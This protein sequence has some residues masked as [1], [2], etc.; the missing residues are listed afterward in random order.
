VVL[1]DPGTVMR[2]D[3]KPVMASPGPSVSLKRCFVR[4]SGDL[5]NCRASRPFRLEA[6]QTLVALS[7]SVLI[8]DAGKYDDSSDAS[9][10][11]E[12]D[13]RNVT[14]V[15]GGNLLLLR[16]ATPRDQPSEDL[17]GIVP[18]S[19]TPDGCL[20]ASLGGASS[21]RALVSI[22]RG[23]A[24]DATLLQ[25]IPWKAGKNAYSFPEFIDQPLSPDDLKSMKST[26]YNR[27][28]WKTFTSETDARFLDMVKLSDI[29]EN[30]AR[31][32]PS[33][34]VLP[35]LKDYGP[36]MEKLPTPGK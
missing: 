3:P 27:E 4:G 5:V 7:G 17:K 11:S 30:L 2:K 35:E 18:V 25:K 6:Q 19:W 1:A 32:R 29:P 33:Q 12:V 26:P 9:P 34:F 13:F 28:G 21:A 31:A 36:T 16:P 24:S 22:E 14:A 10:R 8:V 15:V 23:K 20:F